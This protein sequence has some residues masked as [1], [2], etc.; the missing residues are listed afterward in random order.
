M[1]ETSALPSSRQIGEGAPV[2]LACCPADFCLPRL[3]G[4][5]QTK[6]MV[7]AVER[8]RFPALALVAAI[9]AGQHFAPISV[10]PYALSAAR[11]SGAAH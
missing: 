9:G 2:R 8:R 6:Q 1:A 3:P 7:R 4:V 5:L 11:R 10:D